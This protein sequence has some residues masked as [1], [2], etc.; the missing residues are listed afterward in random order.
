MKQKISIVIF[1]LVWANLV[2]AQAQTIEFHSKSDGYN[3]SFARGARVSGS[4]GQM[5]GN[6][7]YGIFVNV[8]FRQNPDDRNTGAQKKLFFTPADGKLEEVDKKLYYVSP[9][10]EKSLVA[11]KGFLGWS[12]MDNIS[13]HPGLIREPG[14]VRVQVEMDIE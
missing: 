6:E 2:T 10:G 11:E 9:S 13:I 4:F 1:F 7:E 8:R 12:S 5:P 3:E 14:R